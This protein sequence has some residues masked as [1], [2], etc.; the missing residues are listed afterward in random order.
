MRPLACLVPILGLMLLCGCRPS[1]EGNPPADAT[2]HSMTSR[3]IED[4]LKDHTPELMAIAGVMGTAQ[5]EQNGRP[6]IL[7]FVAQ[8]S[9]M[10]RRAIPAEIEGYPVKIQ[11]TGEITPLRRND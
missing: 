8:D 2:E 11:V 9:E 6:C 10:L 3:P 7:V 5:G 1:R 4:V